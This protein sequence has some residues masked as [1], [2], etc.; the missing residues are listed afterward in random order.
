MFA[1]TP[2]IVDPFAGSQYEAELPDQDKE[3]VTISVNTEA[4][5]IHNVTGENTP[6]ISYEEVK[7]YKPT[8]RVEVLAPVEVGWR[9]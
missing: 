2:R 8:H 4:I 9:F 5:R 1:V 7:C 3:Q 6:S